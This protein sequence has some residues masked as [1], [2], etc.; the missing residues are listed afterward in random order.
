[1]RGLSGGSKR[2]PSGCL[3]SG[4][5]TTPAFSRGV[6]ATKLCPNASVHWRVCLDGV[7][8][9]AVQK[10]TRSREFICFLRQ[11]ED[12]PCTGGVPEE[13]CS[14]GGHKTRVFCPRRSPIS[15]PDRDRT[16]NVSFLP[17]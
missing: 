5:E 6:R 7:I 9:A 2:R 1:M 13:T 4:R 11:D 8:P 12:R 10:T 16:E 17:T 3:E 15:R 14:I